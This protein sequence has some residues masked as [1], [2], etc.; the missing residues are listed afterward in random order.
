MAT[1][2]AFESFAGP[3]RAQAQQEMFKIVSG[4]WLSRAVQVAATLGL[5]DL[6][7]GEPR[8]AEEL[9][10]DTGTN[11][12][13]LYRLMRA[14]ASSG[15]YRETD[16]RRFAQTPLSDLLRSDVP[17]SLR[18]SAMSEL[19][20]V[21]YEAW[22]RL[23]QS[24]KTGEAAFE[25]LFGMDPWQYLERHLDVAAVFDESMARLTEAVQR[26]VARVYDFGPYRKVVDVGGGQG[27]LLA[28]ILE[29][30]PHAR[31]V[32]QDRAPVIEHAR[33]ALAHSP[34]GR[35]IDLVPG[36]FFES[37]PAGG[38]LYTLKWILHDWD[39]ERALRI[40][41]NVR[42]AMAPG[43]RV[44]LIECVLPE[45]N[46]PALGPLGDLNMMVMTGGKERCASEFREL[47]A[48]A[49][50]SLTDIYATDS[51]V[52]VIEARAK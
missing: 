21:H 41:K 52:S 47:L 38:D 6:V 25:R 13:A 46:T 44:V 39:D 24:V 17:G 32:L 43:A 14:L 1:A 8:T 12:T 9:S 33:R 35:R 4:F 51:P 16:G 5:S 50:L 11:P 23:L 31:G 45:P 34:A 42:Q 40:L 26:A 37:V 15:I 30:N 22:G 28:G 20:M 27:R 48:A 10:E 3:E 49:G 19:G 36:N 2:T 18:A 29:G 7:A